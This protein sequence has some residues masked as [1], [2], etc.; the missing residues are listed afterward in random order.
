MWHVG[1]GE[2]GGV[3]RMGGTH[4]ARRVVVG[5]K[6]CRGK[7]ERRRTASACMYISG[8]QRS[9]TIKCEITVEGITPPVATA[10]QT[11]LDSSLHLTEDTAVL[12]YSALFHR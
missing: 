5:W 12:K 10:P 6:K 1:R 4:E 2:G 7:G 3:A 9:Y 11:Q 8:S